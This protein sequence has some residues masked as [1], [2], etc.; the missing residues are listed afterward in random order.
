MPGRH[1]FP[2]SRGSDASRQTG[3]CDFGKVQPIKSGVSRISRR[4]LFPLLEGIHIGDTSTNSELNMKAVYVFNLTVLTGF[5]AIGL[6]AA[7]A[8]HA[9]APSGPITAAPSQ[10]APANA[11]KCSESGTAARAAHYHSWRLE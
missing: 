5:A 2:W 10:P 1:I 9:Q 11:A 6:L 8:A 3:Y 4:E 7:E